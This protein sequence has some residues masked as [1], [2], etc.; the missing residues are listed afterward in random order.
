MSLP[1]IQH[2]AVLIEFP[3]MKKKLRFR[4]FTVA[5]E[6]I[7][8]LGSNDGKSSPTL[9]IKQIINNCSLD[10]LDVDK[11]PTF[12]IEYLFIKLR[13][14]SVSNILELTVGDELISV[15]LDDVKV[16]FPDHPLSN[17]IIIDQNNNIGVVLGYPS[18]GD[19]DRPTPEKELRFELIKIVIKSVFKG[20]EVFDIN[21]Y[22][23][24]ELDAF[25]NTLSSA[26]ANKLLEW[27]E[28][29]PYVYLDVTLKN[30]TTK[31]LRG[32]ES[33]FRY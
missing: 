25:I 20:D 32:I 11:L 7:L 16:K 23:P 8:L 31:R 1:I 30:G 12:D 14:I 13:S 9:N 15:N 29:I 18:L 19:I 28:N 22:S 5:E 33:F 4:P 24:E 17:K 26:Q 27:A 3:S 2:P 6:R 10:S 21:D